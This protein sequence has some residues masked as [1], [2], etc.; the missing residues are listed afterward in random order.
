MSI[1][2]TVAEGE[3]VV[4][5]LT[6]YYAGVSA[7]GLGEGQHLAQVANYGP[8]LPVQGVLYECTC[9]V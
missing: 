9:L 2:R 1:Q 6:L 7:F 4:S 5:W 3:V 8:F